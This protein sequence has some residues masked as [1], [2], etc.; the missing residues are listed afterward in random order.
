[1]YYVKEVVNI[2]KEMAQWEGHRL[3]GVDNQI[4]PEYYLQS[5]GTKDFS[6][7]QATC[8]AIGM[9][10]SSFVFY[11]ADLGPGNLIIEHEPK[12]GRVGVIDFEI[13]GFFPRGW[14]RTKFRVSSGM[15]LPDSVTDSPTWWRSEMQKA[16]GGD[17]FEDYSH[18][19]MKWLENDIIGP[20][21]TSYSVSYQSPHRLSYQSIAEL[22]YNR[23]EIYRDLLEYQ[24]IVGSAAPHLLPSASVA[25]KVLLPDILL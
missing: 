7:L 18:A 23:M 3:G 12:S 9:D 14:I 20:C 16:L 4:V 2:C 6:S 13:S 5:S 21:A 8:E 1:M 17:G 25:S 11:H 24:A 22:I 10:C 19:Y 15:D